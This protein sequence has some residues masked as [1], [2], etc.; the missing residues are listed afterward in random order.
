[1]PRLPSFQDLGGAPSGNSGRR[2][3][4]GGE[5][6]FAQANRALVAGAGMQGVGLRALGEG[7]QNLGNALAS[8][9]RAEQDKADEIALNEAKNVWA[10]NK[11]NLDQTLAGERDLK[12]INEFFPDAYN[13]AAEASRESLNESQRARF[14]QWLTPHLVSGL[15]DVQKFSRAIETDQGKAALADRVT[16]FKG[17]ATRAKTQADAVAQLPNIGREVDNA[18]LKG[19]ISSEEAAK[20]KNAATRDVM[21]DWLQAQDDHTQLSILRPANVD[22]AVKQGASFFQSKGW[23]PHQAS[24]IM[25]HL[26][27]ESGGKLDPT[28]VN[29]G[30]GK[31][32]SDSIGIG[33]WNQDRAKA[34]KA[35]AAS[36]GK[37]WTDLGTQLEFAQSEFETTERKAADALRGAKTIDEA[38]S[39]GLKYER[40]HGFEGGLATALGGRDRLRY[41][42]AIYGQLHEGATP[43]DTRISDFIDP[44]KK[45]TMAD[46]AEAR[47]VAR[48]AHLASVMKEQ[49]ATQAA[50]DKVKAGVGINPFDDDGKKDLSRAYKGMVESG[51]RAED[52]TALILDQTKA[53]PEETVQT[54]RQGLAAHDPVAVANA[55]SVASNLTQRGGAGLFEPFGGGKDI[56]NT[57]EK[58][59]HYTDFLGMSAQDAGKKLIEER[60]PSHRAKVRAQADRF[61]LEKNLSDDEKGGVLESELGKHYGAPRLGGWLGTSSAQLDFREG[62]RQSMIEDYKGLIRDNFDDSG[63]YT[64]ARKLA[65]SQLNRVWGTTEINGS[66][67]A[68]R[69]PPESAPA[70][71]GVPDASNQIALQLQEEI[72]KATGHDIDR[73]KIVLEPIEGGVTSRAYWSGQAPPYRV[74]YIDKEGRYQALNPGMAFVPDIDRMHKATEQKFRAAQAVNASPMDAL[75]SE[76]M[77]P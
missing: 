53:I 14:D 44:D 31:D 49:V 18:A 61:G 19:Y 4:G 11:A 2:L 36:K 28:A 12:R 70:L 73:S 55:A 26:L 47:I 17:L 54:I 57:A 66:R 52:A 23:A 5:E 62:D 43:V 24:G 37:P 45:K 40:P 71:N 29:P 13:R 48:E 10:L 38:V 50:I 34:L 56:A 65:R 64:L 74:F 60:D 16:Q 72:K 6:V 7:A 75:P 68:M 77:A 46:G 59:R 8:Y 9:G 42:R 67:V 22:E 69:F 21:T 33:Q 20:L 41:G 76:F 30:D 35:F 27:Y 63:D 25:G 51:M 3:T 1:M 15:E 58:Y 39:A 32:G